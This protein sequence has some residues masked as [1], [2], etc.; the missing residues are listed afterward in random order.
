MCDVLGE[1]TIGS[2]KILFRCKVDNHEWF[3]TPYHILCGQGC[4]VC[5]LRLIS[6]KLKKPN[7]ILKTFSDGS[8]LI[9]IS[10]DKYQ[11]A[12]SRMDI[13]VFEKIKTRIHLNS[14]GYPS[15][16]QEENGKIIAVHHLVLPDVEIRD[17]INRDKTDNRRSNLR[18]V[19]SVQ[20][21]MNKSVLKNN[22]SGST[23]VCWHSQRKKWRAYITVGNKQ[24]TVD[25]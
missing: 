1:Y 3:A 9:D 23:G 13:D 8:I 19:T 11:S 20:N 24:I 25:K 18:E 5:G 17:H 22:N 2:N 15:F 21:G 6:E 12:T 14:H 7:K 16:N 10:T 4:P